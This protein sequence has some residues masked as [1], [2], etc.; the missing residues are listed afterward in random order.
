MTCQRPGVCGPEESAQGIPAHWGFLWLASLISSP[1]HQYVLPQAHRSGFCIIHISHPFLFRLFF[2]RAA[3]PLF[4][5]ISGFFLN[6]NYRRLWIDVIQKEDDR[7][8]SFQTENAAFETNKP[9]K[10]HEPTSTFLN[11]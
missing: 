1:G 4:L 9:L 2:F 10:V 8:P 6:V 5:N 3:F 7:F 11:V